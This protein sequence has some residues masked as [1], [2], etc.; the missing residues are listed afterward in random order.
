MNAENKTSLI[1]LNF[2]AK[3]LNGDVKQDKNDCCGL[4]GRIVRGQQPFFSRNYKVRYGELTKT[5]ISLEFPARRDI[6]RGKGLND[7]GLFGNNQHTPADG[8]QGIFLPQKA[9]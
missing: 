6:T 5:V 8:W 7:N 3:R 1:I 9:S 2:Y 4:N